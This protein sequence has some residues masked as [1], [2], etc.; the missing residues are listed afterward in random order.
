MVVANAIEDLQVAK[1]TLVRL[2]TLSD[3]VDNSTFLVENH[4]RW[5]S[6]DSDTHDVLFAR[7]EEA[8][9]KLSDGLKDLQ[10][11]HAQI[12]EVQD[13]LHHAAKPITA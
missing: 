1:E 8:K 11:L 13:A 7:L 3:E 9:T 6:P 4:H 2:Y 12:A 5:A 10:K